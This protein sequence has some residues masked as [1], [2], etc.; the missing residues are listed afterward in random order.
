VPVAWVGRT[1]TTALQDPVVSLLR[2]LRVS[3]ERLPE[4]FVIIRYYWDVESGATDLDARSRTE[5][6]RQFTDAGIPR[7]GG[8]AELRAEI[9]TGHAAFAGVICENIE[10][11]G[12]DTYDA[13][14]LEKEL[15][16]AGVLLFAADEPIDAQA[17]EG[18]GL[19]VRRMKQGMAEYFRYNLKTQMWNGLKQYVISGHNTGPCPYGYAEDR[20]PHP[21]PMKANM[22]A[23]RARLIPDPERGPWVTRIYQWRVDEK[24]TV[25]T[26]TQRLQTLGAP[27]IDGRP[28]SMGTVYS[29]LRNPKYTGRVVIGRTRNVGDS[30]RT[31]VRTVK[32][33]PRE[34]WTWASD[35]N[36]HEALVSMD[37]W[38]AAQAAGRE[39]ARVADHQE[40]GRNGRPDY[41]LRSRIRCA[42]CQRRMCAKVQP[43]R[44]PGKDYMYYL[45]PHNPNNPR[46]AANCPGHVRAAIRER[47][48]YA[49]VDHIIG[50]LLSHDR[51]AMLAAI[52]PATQAEQD[53]QA[54]DRAEHLRRQILQNKTAQDGLITQ[55]AR[56]GSDTTPAADAM[57]DRITGQFT[58]LYNQ[59]KTLQAELDAATQAQPPAAD[60][61]LLDELPYAAAGITGAPEHIKAKL[62]A[63]FDIQALYRAHKNQAT[64]WATITDATPGITAA[65]LTDPPTSNDPYGNLANTAISP[66]LT[67]AMWNDAKFWAICSN[68]TRWNSRIQGA[69]PRLTHNDGR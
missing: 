60:P 10:R 49:A 43:G 50:T 52:L 65:L 19:L 9:A 47:V 5:V 61:A 16:A 42:Q 44:G 32:K 66:L 30:Q 34:H 54:A 68:L 39:H 3:R 55:L 11:T 27:T 4:G 18:A 64:I 63:A 69:L 24:L 29:I 33:V 46:D 20:T 1:S 26:I 51:A 45:C 6:W 25:Q 59:A 15:H 37:L 40:Q 67:H 7:D 12:R 53:T 36:A 22:G 31:G 62:Y 8:M 41:P 28:W 48:I 23:T 56:M 17:P 35:D 57:R 58:D 38:E 2:Q 14:R 21:N 13:L